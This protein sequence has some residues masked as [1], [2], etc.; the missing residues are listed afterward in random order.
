MTSDAGPYFKQCPMCGHRWQDREGF[1]SDP[2]VRML[3]YMAN[4]ERLELGL[5]LFDHQ[6]CGTTMSLKASLFTDLYDGSV[7]VERQT[8]TEACPGH[9]LHVEE[10]D[11]CPAQCECAYVREVVSICRNWKKAATS[12]RNG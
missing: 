1:L 4:F 7:Y 11:P 6:V 12:V 3:G 9:C 2:D 8:G 10:L 5:F